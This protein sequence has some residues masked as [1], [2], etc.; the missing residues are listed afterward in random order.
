MPGARSLKFV[1]RAGGS[2]ELLPSKCDRVKVEKG[3]LL[4]F[5]TWGG[6]GWGDPLKRNST[7]VA[8]DVDRGLVTREGARRYGV[9]LDENLRVDIKATQALREEMARQRGPSRM[10]DFGGS[11]EELKA[12]C[13]AETGFD[14]R[15]LPLLRLGCAHDS[16]SCPGFRTQR[17]SAIAT[18]FGR[19]AHSQF[20]TEGRVHLRKTCNSV[21]AI[22]LRHE[23]L[24]DPRP[25][26]HTHQAFEFLIRSYKVVSVGY[27]R[28]RAFLMAGRRSY[29]GLLLECLNPSGFAPKPS[30]NR[31]HEACRPPRIPDRFRKISRL[32][33]PSAKR[34]FS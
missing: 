17:D 23:L 18:G 25:K 15:S 14:R 20:M 34:H 5:Q 11:I 27:L 10:F 6:G 7:I 1:Q 19:P 21:L 4:H 16:R 31:F 32:C 3:D 29:H 13:K 30:G 2:R 22:A 12:R 24:W 28:F 8:A 26:D 9:V 33:I